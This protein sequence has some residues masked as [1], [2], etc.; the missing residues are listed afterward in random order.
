MSATGEQVIELRRS[1]NGEDSPAAAAETEAPRGRRIAP[2]TL[3]VSGLAIAAALGGAA[4]ITAPPTTESTDDAYVSADATTVAPKVRGLVG[5]V[6]VRDNQNVRAGD[7]LVRIDPEEFDAR[8][9]SADAD[10]A[11]ADAEV[12]AAH[13]ALVS[14]DAEEQ[15]AAANVTATR[16]SIR[17]AAAEA[18][19][20]GADRARYDALVA[21][22]AVARRD[23]DSYRTTAIGAEQGAARARA[24]LAVSEREAAVTSAKRASLLAALQKAEAQRLRAAAAIDLARQD[25]GH[26]LVRAAIDGVVG[27][28]QVRVGD[29]VQPGSRLLS[30]VPLHDLYVT[31]YF[32]ETQTREMRTGQRV[33]VHVDALGRTLDGRV[34]SFAPGSGATFSLLPFEP[35][36]GNFT[37]IVQRVPV[38]IRFDPGQPALE[39]LRPGLSVTAKVRLRP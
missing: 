5:A 9:E 22:G 20:A 17:A 36:A 13:A 7:P 2:R 27:N 14:L 34:E 15:L 21:T 35:G 8:L 12:A 10:L 38:R 24:M 37:K 25:R 3:V 29:Y 31:A 6:L 1:K 4:W 33:S 26:T 39:S 18:D 32:K 23:A 16:T 19:R 11:N 28:R 30:L